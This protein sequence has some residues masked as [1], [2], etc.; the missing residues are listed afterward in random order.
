M[1]NIQLILIYFVY[2]LAFFL[3]GMA[4]LLEGDRSLDERLRLALRPLA[5]FGILHGINEWMDMFK[6]I[7]NIQ[8][9]Q[10]GESIYFF[11]NLT[12][13]AFSFLS[14]SGFGFSL[15][16]PNMRIRRLSLLAPLFLAAVWAFGLNILSGKYHIMPGYCQVACAWT[17]YAIGIPAA[18]AASIGLVA[19]QRNFR[20]AGMAKFGRDS[21]VASIAFAWYGIAQFFVAPSRL[22]PSTFINEELFEYWFNFPVQL[23]RAGLAIVI[24]IYVIRFMRSFDAEIQQQISR[25]QEL[26][27]QEAKKREEMRGGLIKQIVAAQESERRRIARELHDDTGQSLTAIGLGL[28]GISTQVGT[29][30]PKI[31]QNLRQLEAMT[32][33]SLNELQRMIANLRP[34]H[35]DDL[36]L[37][38]A[39]RWYINDLRNHTDIQI[40]FKSEGDE[41]KVS[42]EVK[43]AVYRIIQ[44][45]ITNAIKHSEAENIFINL[46]FLQRRV[47]V[48]IEDDG[49]GMDLDRFNT[50]KHSSWGLLGMQERTKLLNGSFIIDSKVGRGFRISASLP[51]QQPTIPQL[52]TEDLQN[53]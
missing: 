1:E 3:L 32:T 47:M 24:A 37:A 13:L 50:H 45:A 52:L 38:P 34:A 7:E 21:L 10:S 43:I 29:D 35:L 18:L 15:L 19:Q 20:Q 12:I 44:E 9:G 23:L 53:D 25:L 30:N 5:A 26:Q 17:R 51:Y 6:R 48:E 4:V 40:H 42:D 36:G 8:F 33:N 31:T 11:I 46:N 16:A 39:I 28:R 49:V 27:L 41:V 22:P 2:G 14:L